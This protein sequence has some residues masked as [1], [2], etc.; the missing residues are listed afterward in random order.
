MVN[1]QQPTKADLDY[2]SLIKKIA[3]NGDLCVLGMK[4]TCKTTLLMH[5]ARTIREDSKNRLII[6]ET[7]PKWIKEFD[8][9]PYMTI[10]D[11]DV[12]EK[13]NLPF[14]EE[15]KSYIQWSKDF[16]ISNAEGITEFLKENKSCIFLI[17]CEDMEK[18]S[19]FMTFIIYTVYRKQY[20][21]AKAGSLESVNQNFWFLCEESHKTKA[22]TLVWFLLDSTVLAK[23]TFNRLRK[24]QAE[25]RNLKMH[26]ICV[27]LRLQSLSP[28]IRSTMSILCSRV[29]LDDYQLKVRNLLRNSEFRDVIT[30]LPKGQFVFPEL[31]LLLV[32]EPFQQN[33]IP[34]EV[35]LKTPEPIQPKPKFTF[36]NFLLHGMPKQQEQEQQTTANSEESEE[37]KDD[38][39]E[40]DGVMTLPE[41]DSLLPPDEF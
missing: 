24:M 7:F 2:N 15:D 8:S 22:L 29:S 25:F 36:W 30:E 6:F 17:E 35:K 20:L 26:L 38:E 3:E 21:R 13:E 12:K 5:L 23:K 14:L 34:F 10:K 11:S 39:S 33:G 4:G 1:N 19:A 16:T 28:K 40:F 41:E 37:S 18:I 27:T 9:I 32:T 31:D